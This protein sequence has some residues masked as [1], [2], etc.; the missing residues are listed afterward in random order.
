VKM[1]NKKERH[2]LSQYTIFD[3]ADFMITEKK[4]NKFNKDSFLEHIERGLNA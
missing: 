2:I 4:L 1:I 3:I